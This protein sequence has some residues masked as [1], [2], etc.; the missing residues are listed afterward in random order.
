M[1]S[2]I[3]ISGFLWLLTGCSDG[4][5][6]WA[7]KGA[8][9]D[10]KKF[11]TVKKLAKIYIYYMNSTLK[12]YC[13]EPLVI[14]EGPLELA[15]SYLDE[16]I[17]HNFDK[18]YLTRD[19]KLTL[20]NGEFCPNDFYVVTSK[21]GAAYIQ[22]SRNLLSFIADADT[23]YYVR[24]SANPSARYHGEPI[25]SSK[26][27][28]TELTFVKEDQAKKEINEN[29]RLLNINQTIYKRTR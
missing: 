5:S 4:N 2:Q 26:N 14:S 27:I 7:G 18:R 12:N 8:E 11:E 13:P 25:L 10:A 16:T 28:I 19:F 9:R 21:P 22:I 6:H 29:I 17:A 3:L 20:Q 24:F 1:R 23:N 15:Y